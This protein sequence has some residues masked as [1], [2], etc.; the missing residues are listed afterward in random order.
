[1]KV[2]VA[3]FY[4]NNY[5]SALQ[6]Y[7]LQSVLKELNT[8][9]MVIEEP[10]NNCSRAKQ[11]LR[12]IYYLI[13]PEKYYGFIKKTKRLLEQRFE[14]GKIGKINN[15]VKKNIAIINYDE[16]IKQIA[17]EKVI[18]LAG[19]DQIWSIINSPI[20]SFYTFDYIKNKNV[21]KISY[22]AS[23]GVS[24]LSENQIKYY[25]E[26]LKQFKVISL[27]EKCA[28][29]IL[30]GFFQKSEVR[31][32]VDPTLLLDKSIWRNLC[33]EPQLSE[34]YV[35]VYMLRPDDSLIEMARILAKKNHCKIVY[36]GQ[37]N[38][39]YRNVKT[40]KNAGIEDFLSYIYN[41]EYII[42]N[43][44]HGTVFSILFNKKFVSV[45]IKTTSS[46]VENLLKS[47]NIQY[48]LISDIAELDNAI[49]DYDISSVESKLNELRN[50]SI[51]YLKREIKEEW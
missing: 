42:T 49:I 22:A 50:N 10:K 48:K 32:D 2:F 17:D 39:K 38:R 19:S 4:K 31:C 29:E 30:N 6:A 16:Y 13:K 21:K 46:R 25:S 35:F 28:Y 15:F 36:I 41:A 34:P 24:N 1:M 5:G 20:S 44:F 3:T 33:S 47:L 23:I 7:A 40:I 18:A 45:R 9:S 12:D 11:I 27:R 51:N 14:L 26:T 37:F 43:S 8:I